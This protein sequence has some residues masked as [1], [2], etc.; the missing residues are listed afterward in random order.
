MKRAK[1]RE[2]LKVSGNSSLLSCLWM[3]YASS[4]VME[5]RARLG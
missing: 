2:V 4:R 3:S 5:D 1:K